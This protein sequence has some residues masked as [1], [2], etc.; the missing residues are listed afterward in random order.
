MWRL[1]KNLS[2][3]SP[4]RIFIPAD[5]LGH[6]EEWPIRIRGVLEDFFQRQARLDDV[7]AEDVMDGKGV[8]HR[9]YAGDVHFADLGDVLEDRSELRGEFFQAGFVHREAQAWRRGGLQRE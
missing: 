8:S 5:D 7:F 1:A 2:A 9:L 6:L 3:G 4:R